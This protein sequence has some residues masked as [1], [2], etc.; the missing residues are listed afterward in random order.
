MTEKK[1]EE[2]IP[3]RIFIGGVDAIEELLENEKID[4]IYDLRAKL[5]DGLPSKLSIHQPIVDEEE[6]QVESIKAAINA[7]MDSYENGKNVYFHCNTGRGRAGTIATA[8]LLELGLASTVDEAEEKAKA[9]RPNINV[10]PQFK[11]ALKHIY[12]Q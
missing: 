7:V 4:V 6:N 2:L 12:E 11:D 9:I 10:R 1:Y 8:T 5:K 3:A